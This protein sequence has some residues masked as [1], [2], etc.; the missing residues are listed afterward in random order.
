MSV[1]RNVS[2]LPAPPSGYG[3]LSEA[4]DLRGLK[5]EAKPFSY[6]VA[7]GLYVFGLSAVVLQKHRY[8][9]NTSKGVKKSESCWCGQAWTTAMSLLRLTTFTGNQIKIV[10]LDCLI[11]CWCF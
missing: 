7:I 8:T 2:T 5:M 1:G 11:V 3:V 4:P 10:C 9:V 6:D